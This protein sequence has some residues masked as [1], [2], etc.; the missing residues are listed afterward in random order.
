MEVK[1]KKAGPADSEKIHAMQVAAFHE[2]LNI[3]QD[4]ETN[5]A[6]ESIE[7]IEK[8]LN[9]ENMDYYLISVAETDIG[10]VRV[11]RH[12]KTECRIAPVFILPEHQGYGYAKKV[13]GRL[14]QLY[15]QMRLWKLDTIKQEQ[16]LCYLY[17][18]L[19]YR[20]TGREETIKPGMTLV[21]YE[22][23]MESNGT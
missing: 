14:E 18:S 23:V 19:G 6:S 7:F 10:A 1:L 8:K 5:P 9:T 12:S 22:K 13:F 11:V 21:Y 2:L 4:Y 17:E 15:P 16:K 20:P 3:Y